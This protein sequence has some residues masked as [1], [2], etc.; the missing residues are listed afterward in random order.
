MSEDRASF[1]W[2]GQLAYMSFLFGPDAPK[3][4][5]HWTKLSEEQREWFRQS[6]KHTIDDAE[7]AEPT[8][9]SATETKD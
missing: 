3:R 5:L 6:A 1:E 2:F 7:S 8:D 4:A 9:G